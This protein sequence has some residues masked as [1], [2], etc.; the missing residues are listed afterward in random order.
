MTNSR[1]SITRPM[2]LYAIHAAVI[3][4]LMTV[5]LLSLVPASTV[6]AA[7]KFFT[8]TPVDVA[9]FPNS[10]IHVRC[11]PGDGPITFFAFGLKADALGLKSDADANR[12]L[13]ILSTAFATNKRLSI[14]YNPDDLDGANIGCLTVD[15]RLIRGAVMFHGGS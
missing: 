11:S 15:C 13:S 10:R 1:S 14:L 12:V 8:C 3:V 6:F 7:D 2:F 4:S 9:V 5:S